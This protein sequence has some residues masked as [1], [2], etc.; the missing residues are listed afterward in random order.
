[1]SLLRTAARTAVIT[2]TA[3]RAHGRAAARQQGKWAAQHAAPAPAPVPV[4]VATPAPANLYRD[5]Q[6]DGFRPSPTS[7]GVNV[8]TLHYGIEEFEIDPDTDGRTVLGWFTQAE[9]SRHAGVA[10]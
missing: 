2:S 4:P 8:A 1:M 10:G 3:T 7:R 6:G 9:R 5:V